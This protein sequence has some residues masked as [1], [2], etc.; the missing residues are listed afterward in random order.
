MLHVYFFNMNITTAIFLSIL[1]LSPH[2]IRKLEY[3][4]VFSQ[5]HAVHI[6]SVGDA[7]E[8]REENNF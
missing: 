8:G 4:E 1:L 5:N 6:H 2:N 3:Y 7:K